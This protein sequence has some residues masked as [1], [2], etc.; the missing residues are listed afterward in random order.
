MVIIGVPAING[1]GGIEG[2]QT[3]GTR[4][5]RELSRLLEVGG[6]FRERS[7]GGGVEESD[8]TF[9]ID[10]REDFTKVLRLNAG[11]RRL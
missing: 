5:E 2:N 9:G 4:G 10:C 1:A 7:L 8:M 11:N 6:L 3:F